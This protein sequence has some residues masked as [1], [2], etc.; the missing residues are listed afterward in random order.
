MTD[1]CHEKT[2]DSPP[3]SVSRRLT[4][5][6]PGG[7]GGVRIGSCAAYPTSSQVLLRLTK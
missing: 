7:G 4:V 6:A 3:E 1:A 2:L 5:R